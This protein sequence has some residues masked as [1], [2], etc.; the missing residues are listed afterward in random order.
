MYEDDKVIGSGW[1]IEATW[2]IIKRNLDKIT[3]IKIWS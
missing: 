1:I 3:I 2:L